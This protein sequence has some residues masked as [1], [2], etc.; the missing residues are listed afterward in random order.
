MALH[1]NV[2]PQAPDDRSL[3]LAAEVLQAGGVVGP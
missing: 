3:V 2:D 1:M